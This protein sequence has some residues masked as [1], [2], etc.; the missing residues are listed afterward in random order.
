M[1]RLAASL[2]LASALAAVSAYAVSID[3]GNGLRAAWEGQAINAVEVA[4]KALPGVTARLELLDPRTQ[5]PADA[6]QFALQA[7]LEAK[8]GALWLNGVVTV[9]GTNDAVAD[10]VL[11]VE[12][13][14]LATGDGTTEPLLLAAK[15]V[16]KLPIAPLRTLADG[17]DQLTLA[18][19][20]DAPYVFEFRGLPAEKAV[21]M[22]LPLGFSNQAA[23]AFQMKAPFSIVI[24]ATTPKWHFRSAL[25]EYYRLFPAR[26]ERVE[27]RHGGWF[28][29]N[30]TKNIPDPQHFAFH[31]GQGSIEEDHDRNM[32]M[33]PYN[34]TGSE[35]IEL[36]GP[37]LPKDYDDAIRQMS[38]LETKIAPAAWRM[39][40][41]ALDEQVRHGG[42]YA[43]R[44]V[45]DRPDLSRNAFQSL[46][47][48]EPIKTPVVVTAWSKAENVAA[49][50]APGDYSIYIDCLLADGSY[51]FGQCAVFKPGTH[52]WEKAEWIIQPRQ[53]LVELR[54]YAMFRNR[55]GTAWFDDITICRQGKPETNLLENGEFESMGVRKD[56]VFVRDNALTDEKDHYRVLI[57]D[58][59]GSDEPPPTPLSLLRFICNVDPDLRN[60]DARPTPAS[61]G[62]NFFDTL[63]K[64]NSGI[65]GCY[66]DGSGAWTCWYLSH[67][68]DHFRFV[69]HPLTYEPTTFRVAQHG[70]FQMFKWLRCIQDRYRA[71]G[72][73]ILGNQGPS[74]DAWTSYTA[75]DI[76]GIESS[77]FQDHALMG[78]HRFGGYQKPV[79]PM[80]FVNLH[81]L[82]DRA[83]AEE[84]VLA[85]AQ[86]G[87]FPSTG[88]LVR[89][90]YAS[91]GDVCHSYYPALVEMSQA[92]WEPE[93]LVD[94]VHA[95]RFGGGEPVYL[96]VRAPETPRRGKLVVHPDLFRGI[97]APVV[98]DAVQLSPVPAQVTPQG[99]EIE[100]ADGAAVL[101]ILR[102]SSAA[103]ARQW[104]LERAARHCENAAIVR[105]KS[106][107]TDRLKAIAKDLRGLKPEGDAG[108]GAVLARVQTERTK[109]AQEPDGLEKTSQ[110]L[111]LLDAERTVAEWLLF[112]GGATLELAG[113]R[114][115]PA[116]QPASLAAQF[117]PAQTGATLLGSWAF[118]DRNIL[119]LAKPELPG[120][121]TPGAQPVVVQRDLPGA[122]QVRTALRVPVAGA[123]PV[124]VVRAANVFF[125][126]VATARVE[127]TADPAGKAFLYRVIVQRLT[128]PCPLLVKAA[129]AG[130]VIEPTQVELAPDQTIAQFRV[131]AT[132]SK[133][134]VVG[135]KF[136]V[137]TA[138]GKLVAEAASEFRSLPMPPDGDVALLSLG[139]TVAADSSYSE[140]QPE[141][142]ID[143]VWETSALHWT[144]KAWASADRADKDGHWLEI[145]L[146]K[147]T[148]ISQVWLYWCID[149]NHVFSSRNYD[150]DIWEGNAWKTVAQV[151]DNPLSTV[152]KHTWP[153]SVTE[154]V[155]LHQ[156]DTGGPASRPHIMWVTEVCLYNRGTLN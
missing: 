127:R 117:N 120:T 59:W 12:G 140:Y 44:A 18:M 138:Q 61:R 25:A 32:G 28:F 33:F 123:E 1:R 91:F 80:N 100:V 23:P 148:P 13:V 73:T 52:D 102:V 75:L 34:E 10:L 109:V 65:D 145:R 54:V 5:K 51:Q 132:E 67:R 139:A 74:T 68:P 136:G 78:Y 98:M 4:G 118:P 35:T 101:T 84:F 96:T 70:R 60:P 37:G 103:N 130:A 154:K 135:L 46:M 90:G 2:A 108:I 39:T 122:G 89:E 128:E 111:E 11:R 149:N 113:A 55:T 22:R 38:D 147:P 3:A 94:G 125:S 155:R 107:N 9:N 95:E 20:A 24:C 36:A 53:P 19:P 16:N 115:V 49:G 15:F 27:K 146:P 82:D 45:A 50:P 152:S 69:S 92:G 119:R 133:T 99:I 30:E 6:A 57:T 71:Q 77:I 126:P 141:T 129:G 86:W 26:F 8:N 124:T 64:G 150:V 42:K 87:H 72:R 131:A 40:G 85:S 134:E 105:G 142:A 48:D 56:I 79:L 97:D 29:A 104:Q 58:N 144:R 47:L 153:S 110:A 76:I 41:G 7:Q 137:H 81:K 151:R 83:T 112:T 66:I 116:S 62:L 17:Q 156:L 114:V 93:P 121:L 21:V 143:G 63:F 43:F 88:R 31:E 106:E 14:A